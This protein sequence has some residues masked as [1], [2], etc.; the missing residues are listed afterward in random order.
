MLRD[1]TTPSVFPTYYLLGILLLGGCAA[2]EC[3]S[4]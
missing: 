2:L 4:Y 1:S 3:E